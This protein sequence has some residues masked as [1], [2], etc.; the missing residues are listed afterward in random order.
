PFLS[1][2]HVKPFD[3]VWT[4]LEEPSGWV[5]VI[6]ALFTTEA[7]A[8][9]F[10][11]VMYSGSVFGTSSLGSADAEVARAAR[12]YAEPNRRESV[13]L[14]HAYLLEVGKPNIN[15]TPAPNGRILQL[16]SQADICGEVARIQG[17]QK[18]AVLT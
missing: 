5:M 18:R 4:V 2:K 10:T 13:E 8:A 7:G 12:S 15:C 6:V 9:V 16:A 17:R 11:L 14:V 1:I 3:P